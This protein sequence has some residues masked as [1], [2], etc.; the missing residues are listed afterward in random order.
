MDGDASWCDAFSP[1]KG[2]GGGGGGDE[3]IYWIIDKLGLFCPP[4]FKVYLDTYT[5]STRESGRE[6]TL[7]FDLLLV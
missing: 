3:H 1:I 5:P 2:G 6:S 7:H 4:S